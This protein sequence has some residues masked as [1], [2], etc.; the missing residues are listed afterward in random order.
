MYYQSS[1]AAYCIVFTESK[2]QQ[3]QAADVELTTIW[4]KIVFLE[5][6]IRLTHFSEGKDIYRWLIPVD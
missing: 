5:K 2:A 4:E 6:C 3:N 1:A